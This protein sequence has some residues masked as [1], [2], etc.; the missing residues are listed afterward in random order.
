MKRAA[1]ILIIILLLTAVA[2]AFVGASSAPPAPMGT[3]NVSQAGYLNRVVAGVRAHF[4]NGKAEMQRV[5]IAKQEVKSFRMT[6]VLRLH[7]GQPLKTVI[8]ASCPDRERLT[9]TI[10]ERVFHAVRI[11]T[12]AYTEQQDGT[13]LVQDIPALGWAPCGQDPGQ[14]AP[15]AVM[16]EGRDPSVVLAKLAER[17]EIERGAF[18]TTP[19]GNCQ[20]WV[21]RLK[22]A[23]GA[24]HGHG[25]GGLSY[26][27]C[28]DSKH[29]P[30]AVSMGSGGMVTSYSDWNQAIQIDAPKM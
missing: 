20:Q 17:S 18:V 3:V 23:G 27:V 24:E 12:K 30:V 2:L 19:D 8:E 1:L 5:S 14:P 21:V 15:W 26:T 9:T 28:L 6:T 11:G 29:L 7:P 16:N 4:T 25:A 10:G 22:L 13:W